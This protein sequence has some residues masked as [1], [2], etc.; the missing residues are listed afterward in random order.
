MRA[1][2]AVM[3]VEG[4]RQRCTSLSRR[5]RLLAGVLPQL[6]VTGAISGNFFTLFTLG[7]CRASIDSPTRDAGEDGNS[8]TAP[9]AGAGKLPQFFFT[10]QP[11]N[12][13]Q[14]CGFPLPFFFD[15][16]SPSWYIPET[17]QQ[18]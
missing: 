6:L 11:S 12:G 3:L 17:G 15:V 14:V 8:A 9:V 5:F 1:R 2:P 4:M 18:P 7:H 10:F 16:F 13:F